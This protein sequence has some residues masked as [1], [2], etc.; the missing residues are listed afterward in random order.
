MSGNHG[1]RQSLFCDADTQGASAHVGDRCRSTCA[2]EVM[3]IQ[4]RPRWKIDQVHL[5]Q[6]GELR[7]KR[8]SNASYI[9]EAGDG[10]VRIIAR[11]DGLLQVAQWLQTSDLLKRYHV[12]RQLVDYVS[13][14]L[15]FL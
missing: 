6:Y 1:Q 9:W 2:G 10:P 15:K 7:Q 4:G 5:L 12:G 13:E 14:Q 8:D 3:N 11:A